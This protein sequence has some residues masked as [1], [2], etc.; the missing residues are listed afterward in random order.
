MARLSLLRM[1]RGRKL[2]VALIATGVVILFPGVVA[3]LEAGADAEEVVRGGIDWGFF[4]L[5][6]FLLPVLFTSGSIGEEVEARTLHFV[7]MRPVPRAAIA[8]GKYLVGAGAGLAILW[9]GLIALHVVGFASTPSAMIDELPDT[10]RAG[11]AASLLVLAYSGICLLWGALVPE[12]AGM[13]SVVWLGFI[14][15]FVALMPGVL[16]FAALSH[17]AREL[18]GIERAGWTDWVVDVELWVCATVVVS[19]WLVFTVL[20][21]L[22]V[23]LSELRFGKA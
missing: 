3:L 23:Q 13:V 15:W 7:A 16:R 20:G 18:G 1:L 14:E 10:A 4:R 21:V 19:G 17:F 8:L 5:L 12:A 2:W 9:A 22:V 11:G 6:V